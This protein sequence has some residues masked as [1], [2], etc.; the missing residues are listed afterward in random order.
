MVDKNQTRNEN[1]LLQLDSDSNIRK[2]IKD[3]NRTVKIE[4]VIYS[5]KINKINHYGFNQE[6]SILITDK[7]VYNLKKKGMLSD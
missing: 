2:F 7:A 5:D 4:K 6:R 3:G 1:D